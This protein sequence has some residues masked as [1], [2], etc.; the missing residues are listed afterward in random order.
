[1]EGER[2]ATLDASVINSKHNLFTGINEVKIGVRKLVVWPYA[3]KVISE[4]LLLLAYIFAA[5]RRLNKIGKIGL[6]GNHV[7]IQWVGRRVTKA[8]HSPSQSL[9]GNLPQYRENRIIWLLGY[10]VALL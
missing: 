5:W 1:M 3:C 6:L 4:N 8:M 7:A 10:L 2:R 9:I